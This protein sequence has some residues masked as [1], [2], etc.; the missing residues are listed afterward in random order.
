MS[1]LEEKDAAASSQQP[2]SPWRERFARLERLAANNEPAFAWAWLLVLLAVPTVC[3]LIASA[4]HTFLGIDCGYY[5]SIATKV[6]DGYGFTT[7]VSILHKAD[8]SFPAPTSAYPL[9]PLMWGYMARIVPL[10]LLARWMPVIFYLVAIVFCFLWIR[11]LYPRPL[12]PRYLPGF[13][14][15]HVCAIVLAFSNFYVFTIYPEVEG[16]AYTLLFIAFWRFNRLFIRPSLLAGLEMGVWLGLIVMARPQLV[17][18][19]GVAFLVLGY[20]VVA[21][22]AQRVRYA[23]MLAVCVLAF[24]ATAAPW[25][26]YTW[27]FA[28]DATVMQ[29]LG[30]AS[31]RPNRVLSNLVGLQPAT[32][33]TEWLLDRLSSFPIAFA[34]SSPRSY[35]AVYAKFHYAAVLTL[36]AAIYFGV[37]E[38]ARDGVERLRRQI[39]DPAFLPHLY[40]VGYGTAAFLALHTMHTGHWYFQRRHA[41]GSVVFFALMLSYLLLFKHRVTKLLGALI[42]AIGLMFAFDR[43]FVIT[44]DPIKG[45]YQETEAVGSWIAKQRRLEPD[46]VIAMRNPQ[47]VGYRFPEVGF[48]WFTDETTAEDFE[49]MAVVLGVDYVAIP[50]G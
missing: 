3:H 2:E 36:P 29:V 31:V 1:A 35:E 13:Q 42:L 27:S 26:L 25:F 14:A 6:R 24:V 11:A 32:T 40:A 7:N 41:L 18:S 20:A 28:P 21:I 33:A 44:A 22:A 39:C 48:H 16:L 43:L 5:A 10:E 8:L 9:W 12:F 38:V 4:R 50:K 17:P 49:Q 45:E 47:I 37:K 30:F 46:L 34:W 15:A 23:G 19:S